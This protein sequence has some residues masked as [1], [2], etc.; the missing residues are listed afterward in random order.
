MAARTTTRKTPEPVKAA[1]VKNVGLPKLSVEVEIFN[2]KGE[3]EKIEVEFTSLTYLPLGV[4][5]MHRDNFT[6]QLFAAVEWAMDEKN[7]AIVDKMPSPQL[8]DLY[9]RMQ[10]ASEVEVGESDGSS[11]TS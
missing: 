9:T 5:R 3:G 8:F 6:A 2:S 7:L 10:A 1:A 4:V 11:T